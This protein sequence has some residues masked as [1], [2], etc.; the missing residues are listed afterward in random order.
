MET[1]RLVWRLSLLTVG[2]LVTTLSLAQIT[3]TS[4]IPGGGTPPA[5]STPS[6]GAI[7]DPAQ[8]QPGMVKDSAFTSTAATVST[9]SLPDA[10][11]D[12]AVDA[13]NKGDKAASAKALQMGIAGIESEVAQKPT[14]FKDKVLAQVSKLKTLLPL[15]AGGGLGGNVLQ[16]AVGLT[17]LASGANRLEGLMSAGSLIGNAGKLTSS[18]SGIGSAMSALGGGTQTAGQSLISTAMSGVS[19]LSGGGAM[20]KAAEPAVRNQLGSVLS[21]VKGAL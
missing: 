1:I 10:Q 18:L 15:I 2:C 8:S 14:S 16:K 17:K 3:T 21:F 19:K 13:L 12:K 11:L 20:A 6:S 7:K 9:D 4:T 5:M